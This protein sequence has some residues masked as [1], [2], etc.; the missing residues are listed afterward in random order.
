MILILPDEGFCEAAAKGGAMYDPESDKAFIDTIRKHLD[1][2]IRVVDVH[3]NFNSP[4]C[5][6][7]IAD[8]VMSIEQAVSESKGD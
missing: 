6:K 3:G 5:Q 2:R 8:A 1:S 4:A 7:A